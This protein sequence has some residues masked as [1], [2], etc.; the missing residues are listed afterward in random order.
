[1]EHLRDPLTVAA[2]CGFRNADALRSA[3]Q[4]VLHVAPSQYRAR[5]RS[6]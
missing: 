1:M 3:F 2:E 6:A 5:F 4:R